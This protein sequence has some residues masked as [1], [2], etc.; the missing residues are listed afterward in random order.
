MIKTTDFKSM[1]SDAA[2]NKTVDKSKS[3]RNGECTLLELR[4]EATEQLYKAGMKKSGFLKDLHYEIL[5]KMEKEKFNFHYNYMVKIG[6]FT[7][8]YTTMLPFAS[9]PID[10]KVLQKSNIKDMESR[11]RCRLIK[12]EFEKKYDNFPFELNCYIDK[13]LHTKEEMFLYATVEFKTEPYL[14]HPWMY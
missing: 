4:K 8:D 1:S 10:Y 5:N 14:R 13:S 9:K 2:I 12:E 11:H 7:L 3:C 6:G